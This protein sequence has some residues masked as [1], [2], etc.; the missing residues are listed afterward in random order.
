MP[1]AKTLTKDKLNRVLLVASEGRYGFR[2][3]MMLLMSFWS[4]MRV[5]EIGALKIGDVL[6]ADG[7]VKD[8]IRLKPEQTKGRK[9]RTVMLGEKLQGELQW[10][11]SKI[12][13]TKKE[14]PLFQS[15][16]GGHFNRNALVQ[17]FKKIYVLANIDGAS[18][19]SGRRTFITR[20]ANKGV[21]VRVLQALAG[22]S[23]IATTQ[24][25][26]DVNDE[27]LKRAVDML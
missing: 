23:S 20:L 16:Q 21:G 13:I 19:H 18:S 12:D 8:E 22:H 14:L 27:M 4:G 24:L 10:Y 17:K 26:I 11:I 5:G 2:D 15:Q 3:R 1:Q 6:G 7:R 25:Y 9:Y